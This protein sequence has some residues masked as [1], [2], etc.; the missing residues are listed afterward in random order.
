MSA[1]SYPTQPR[2]RASVATSSTSDGIVQDGII[3]HHLLQ[4]QCGEENT[5]PPSHTPDTL[6]K[7]SLI[8]RLT[9]AA[10]WHIHAA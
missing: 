7:K 5:H 6:A 10:V 4:F 9:A 2:E 1:C 8:S 3:G